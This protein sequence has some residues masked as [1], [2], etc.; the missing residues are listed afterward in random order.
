MVLGLA[1][2]IAGIILLT[3]ASTVLA[4][5][6]EVL[7]IGAGLDLLVTGALGHCPLYNKLG[8]V[9]NSLRRPS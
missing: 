7:L 9:P 5:V 8:H 6:L 3:T 4:I 2:A 1:G